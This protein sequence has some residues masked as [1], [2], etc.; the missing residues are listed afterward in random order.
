MPKKDKIHDKIVSVLLELAKKDTNTYFDVKKNVP[1]FKVSPEFPKYTPDIHA[2]VK[3]SQGEVDIFQV[4][5]G[6]SVEVA[7]FDF[8][9][10]SMVERVRWL[11][12]V[13]APQRRPGYCWKRSDVFHLRDA[14][15]KLLA[16]PYNRN[17]KCMLSRNC[18]LEL[19][20]EDLKSPEC[21]RK[22]IT[23]WYDT[24]SVLP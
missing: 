6:E 2:F 16:A 9:R 23:S 17:L 8:L 1:Q 21:I 11:H 3:K 19:T 14:L 18:V 4:W 22:R 24:T 10:C 5:R 13:T 20:K 12:I 15:L 7:V